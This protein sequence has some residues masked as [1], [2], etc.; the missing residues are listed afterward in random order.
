[1][2]RILHKHFW[3]FWG[4]LFFSVPAFAQFDVTGIVTDETTGEPLIGAAVKLKGTA[5]GV[6][7]DLNGSF[8]VTV[9]GSQ[10]VLQFSYIGYVS[11]DV[12]VTSA[13]GTLNV[14][15]SEDIGRLEE[16]VVTGLATSVKRSN[17]ANAVST[18]S[19]SE[20]TGT[21]SQP[22][23]DA[24]I[25]GKVTGANIVQSSG[26]PGGGIAIRLRGVSSITGQNQPLFI[27]D[28]V[29]LSNAEVPSGLRFASGANSASEENASNRIAD[30]NPDDIENIEILKGPSAAAIYGTR[31]N[32]GVVII[33]T[34]RGKEG[35]R[36]QLN[37]SQDLGVNRAIKLLGMRNW[38]EESVREAFDEEEAQRFV[39]ARN[40]GRI[41]DY[42]QEIYGET[43]LISQSNL[44][45]TGGG[46]K[47]KF[48]IG[49]S[50]RDEEGIIKGTGFERNSIRLNLDHKISDRFSISTGSNYVNSE[51]RRG[52]TGNENEGGL[53][54]GYNLAFTRPWVDLHADEFGNFPNNPNA[55]GNPLFVRARTINEEGVDRFI[56]SAQLRANIIKTEKTLLTATLNGGLDF[57][58]NQTFVYVPREHQAQ[59]TQ[60]GFIGQG[61]NGVRNINN[62]GFLV[63]ENYLNDGSLILTS[64][65]GYSYL[66]FNRNFTFNQGTQL[67]PGPVNIGQAAA[68]RII[69]T[70]Q[71]EE[72]FGLVFQQEANFKDRI[73]ATAGI[74][75]DKSNLNADPN[76]YYY[77]PKASL[78]VNI[79]NFDF[80]KV[81]AINQFKLRAAYGQTGSTAGFGSLYTPLSVLGVDAQAGLLVQGQR[82]RDDLQPETASEFEFGL[83]MSFFDSR[84]GFEATYYNRNVEDLILDRALPSSSGFTVEVGNFADLQNKG[85]EF[86]LSAT[87]VNAQNLRWS[88]QTNFWF[89]RSR[90]TRLAVP[91]YAPAG[92]AFG[93]SL[94]TFYV[95]EGEP[96]TQ[97]KG[98][99]EGNVVTV[100]D[101]EPDFQLSFFN[102]FTFFKNFDFS[103]LLHRK[104]GGDNLNLTRLLTDLGQ[105]TPDLD[106][107]EGQQR[108]QLGFV[109]TRFVE[110]ASYWRMRELALYYT[111]PSAAYSGF[112]GNFLRRARIGVSARNL[113]TITNYSSYDPEVSVK[114]GSGLSTGV[115]VTPF[116]SMKQYYFHLSI[117]L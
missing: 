20:L 109:A 38:T 96:I 106:T 7:T 8:S 110:D 6:V 58:T 69:Q 67:L 73:V 90:V 82:G 70:N 23:L 80:W 104:Q 1:M 68:T 97:I 74:R 72:E 45:V 25:Y 116:P 27:V 50:V 78:A 61:K 4:L 19:G 33:T 84:L 62:Q 102:Q 11:E 75:A 28:G 111:I 114:G 77:F 43:G 44:S 108:Q 18:I 103:F 40:A 16:V 37:F 36:T 115:E 89:N 60:Q 39:A 14:S 55:S 94:G 46:E 51:T 26:A 15:L 66:N 107:E 52:F 79:A 57:F 112:A 42:E 105:T 32:A 49:A 17:L 76:R 54:Y 71:R 113:F 22:T 56:Q 98:R 88:S 12:S 65:A 2:K 93:L 81:N 63:W 100:G 64:Q 9:P 21:T 30:L 13:T 41:F 31:A 29:Y 99:V 5:Q 95:E 83:D 101:T 47:T 59:G 85:F 92:S 34:K 91:A 48:F 24:A 53:S 10:G 35:G 117:G 86:G 3:V 87:P